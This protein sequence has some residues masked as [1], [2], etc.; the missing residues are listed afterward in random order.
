MSGP[1]CREFTAPL[2]RRVD[3]AVKLAR[4]PLIRAGVPAEAR[5][6][7]AAVL[8]STA[9]GLL[10]HLGPWQARHRFGVVVGHIWRVK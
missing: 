5:P 6:I 9:V 8:I 4:K 7:C 3:L 1:A 2:G 10:Y